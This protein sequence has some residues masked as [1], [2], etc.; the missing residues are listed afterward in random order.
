MKQLLK[1]Y[2]SLLLIAGAVVL[3]DQATKEWVRN[4]LALSQIYRPDLWITH[5]VRITHIENS[6][7]AIGFFSQGGKLIFFVML[8]I[9]LAVIVLYP[10]VAKLGWAP[11]LALGLVLGGGIGNMIDR[12]MQNF[13]VTDFISILFFPIFNIA[14]LAVVTGCGLLL[15][16]YYRQDNLEK[17]ALA[18]PGDE[19][20]QAPPPGEPPPA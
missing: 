20:T 12:L 16:W 19:Q 18:A 11:A 17:Q 4:N 6:G 8:L 10:R 15:V 14:D 3:L 1:S 13:V 7:A 5:Y 2:L 9:N